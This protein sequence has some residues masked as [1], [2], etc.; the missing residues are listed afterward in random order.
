MEES[1]QQ[2]IDIYN[3]RKSYLWWFLA[4][5]FIRKYFLCFKCQMLNE[6]VL[7]F[8][9]S[10]Y[11]KYSYKQC[12]YNIVKTHVSFK[13]NNTNLTKYIT[14]TSG[15]SYTQVLCSHVPARFLKYTI[16]L[17]LLLVCCCA[18]NFKKYR[19]WKCCFNWYNK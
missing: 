7:L 19:F 9:I 5:H 13:V 10:I 17:L 2:L 11:S 16:S 3:E 1:F 4:I 8:K 14:C 15:T 12:F 18:N 6:D